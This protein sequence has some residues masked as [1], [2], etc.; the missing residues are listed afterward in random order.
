MG[1]DGNRIPG[2]SGWTFETT[3]QSRFE[4]G[5]LEIP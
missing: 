1:D 5:L 2:V 4:S 3:S